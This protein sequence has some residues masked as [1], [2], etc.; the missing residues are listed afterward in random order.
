[1]FF[2]HIFILTQRYKFNATHAISMKDSPANSSNNS[3][4]QID[5]M[6]QHFTSHAAQD[7]SGC[8]WG[9]TS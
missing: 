5:S 3:N 9:G 8:A 4:S 6:K 2:L 7:I 1:M